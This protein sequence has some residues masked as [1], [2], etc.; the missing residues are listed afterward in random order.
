VE[1]ESDKENSDLVSLRS[2]AELSTLINTLETAYQMHKIDE[3]YSSA[4]ELK[5]QGIPL[6]PRISDLL[7]KV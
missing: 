5:K 1:E 7:R 3:A 6:P 4:Q 2:E